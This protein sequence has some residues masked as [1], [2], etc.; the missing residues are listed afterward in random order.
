MIFAISFPVGDYK[1]AYVRKNTDAT[2]L[3]IARLCSNLAKVVPDC[4]IEILAE[5]AVR[6]LPGSEIA[7]MLPFKGYKSFPGVRDIAFLEFERDGLV[8]VETPNLAGGY[9]VEELDKLIEKIDPVTKNWKIVPGRHV[10]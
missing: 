8:W 9:M 3:D 7:F 4:G 2:M 5:F 6:M 1:A 10:Y